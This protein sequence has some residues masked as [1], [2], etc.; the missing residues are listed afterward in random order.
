MHMMKSRHRKSIIRIVV[1]ALAAAVL[2]APWLAAFAR[3]NGTIPA[4]A[5]PPRWTTGDLDVFF[6]D[7][8]QQLVGERPV[9]GAPSVAASP[10]LGSGPQTTPET[11]AGAP[12]WSALI[13]ADVLEDEVKAI[14]LRLSTSLASASDFKAG[15]FKQCRD[16]FYQL[17]VMFKVAGLFDGRVRWKDDGAALSE[18]FLMASYQ[19]REATDEAYVVARR[20]QEDLNLVIRGEQ[21][22]TAPPAQPPP[23]KFLADIKPLMRRM[24]T[25][26]RD[27][28][29]PPLSGEAEFDESTDQVQHE[30]QILAVMSREIARDVFDHFDE[31][32][33]QEH[34][35]ALR[36]A[37]RELSD[38]AAR[39]DFHRASTAGASIG[40]SCANCHA[41]YRG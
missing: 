21:L 9:P 12:S 3:Q 22:Q 11:P 18:L 13:S 30:A 14:N 5:R 36:T 16:D 19:S 28:I 23:R 8:R 32:F 1:S 10:P 15:G 2:S 41:D 39:R 17:A 34:V 25:A 6:P 38:A 29:Q 26:Y 7:A 40:R 20:R 31:E 35:A 4:R 37:S 27:R 24:E 33:Y